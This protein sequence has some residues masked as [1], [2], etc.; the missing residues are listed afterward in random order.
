MRGRPYDLV[1]VAGGFRHLTRPA[2]ADAIR[3]AIGSSERMIDLSQSEALEA[4]GR[5]SS[6]IPW[7]SSPESGSRR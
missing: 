6:P 1:A 2:Y 5:I 3:T 4:P 7:S